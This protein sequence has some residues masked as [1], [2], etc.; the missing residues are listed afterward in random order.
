MWVGIGCFCMMYLP[1]KILSHRTGRGNPS[2]QGAEK[3]QKVR[4][5]PGMVLPRDK[6]ESKGR[7]STDDHKDGGQRMSCVHGVLV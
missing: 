1:R 2:P 6:P 3:G 4:D 5:K 7:N